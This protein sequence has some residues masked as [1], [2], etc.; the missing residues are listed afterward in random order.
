MYLT[1]YIERMGTGTKDM[2]VRCREAELPEPEFAVS[3]GIFITTIRRK[4]SVDT[5]KITRQV[6]GKSLW[7]LSVW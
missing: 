6:P 5:S 3:M 1:K 4:V 2:I 7:R